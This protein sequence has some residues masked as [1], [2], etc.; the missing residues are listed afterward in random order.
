MNHATQARLKDVLHYEPST[1]VFTWL[2]VTS[3]R[4][5]IG[6][7]AGSIRENGYRDIRFDGKAVRAHRLAWLYMTG[8]WP[9]GHLDH[10]NLKRDDNWWENLRP[11]TRTQNNCNMSIRSD[12]KTGVKGIC[13]NTEKRKWMVTISAA[14][15]TKNLGCF[16]DFDLAK[17]VIT[18]ARNE[19]H[20]DFACHGG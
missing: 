15:V 16:K 13:W 6:D 7:Q 18:S 1:G 19:M 20:G 12:N 4:I 8:E 14:G 11:A 17:E 9:D 10:K 5:R 2:K 3:N